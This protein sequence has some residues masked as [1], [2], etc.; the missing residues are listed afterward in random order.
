MLYHI[1]RQ[2]NCEWWIGKDV[3]EHDNDLFLSTLT[4]SDCEELRNLNQENQGP[5]LQD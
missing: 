5:R 1:E 2:D 4:S 3:R